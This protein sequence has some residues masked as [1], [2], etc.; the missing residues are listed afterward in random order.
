MNTADAVARDISPGKHFCHT[1]NGDRVWALSRGVQRCEG[2]GQR[3]PCA[4]KS[5]THQD[6]QA[7]RQARAESVIEP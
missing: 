5:C 4:S 6:C 1:C 2:C 3:F 7:A